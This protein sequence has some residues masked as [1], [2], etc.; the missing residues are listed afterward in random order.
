VKQIFQNEGM[1]T[2]FTEENNIFSSRGTKKIEKKE[3]NFSDCIQNRV[4][5]SG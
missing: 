4:L 5:E 2:Y 3:Q 1:N